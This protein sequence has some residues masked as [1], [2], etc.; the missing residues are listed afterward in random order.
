MIRLIAAV[1]FLVTLAS[2]CQQKKPFE[3]RGLMDI[4]GNVATSLKSDNTASRL[5]AVTVSGNCRGSR[6]IAVIEVDGLLINKNISGTGSMGENPVAL[7]REK[8]NAVACDPTIAAVVLRVNS[9]GGGVTA[10]DIMSNDLLRLKARRQIP[11]VACHL[12]V[13]TG[14][15]Y[16]L[17]TYADAILAHPTSVVGGIGVILNAYNLEDAMGNVGIVSIPIKAGEMIDTL[18]PDR[19]MEDKEREMLQAMANTFHQRIIAQVKHTR[20]DLI[21]AGD[22]FDGRVFSG[23]QAL[24]LGLI[25]Q[26][27][28]ID[29]AIQLA[30]ELGGVDASGGVVMYRR[31]NDRAHTMLDI[32]PNDPLQTSLLNLKIPGLDRS[33]M[34]MFL[35][36]WQ[37]DPSLGGA[38][39]G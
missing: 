13:G 11:V 7:F 19:A 15:A 3:F 33:S 34:P 20:P 25:D 35:Y 1:A 17:S 18:S 28:Y 31:D 22:L 37:S 39:D 21:D 14:G 24:E 23:Q 6:R 32:T 8:L 5:A 30:R 2:G 38:T 12:V 16:Y 29:D 9:P 26:I 4:S 36:L 27:G 10:T